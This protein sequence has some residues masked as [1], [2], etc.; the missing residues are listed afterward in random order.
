MRR[1]GLTVALSA[2]AIALAAGGAQAAT[3]PGKYVVPGNVPGNVPGRAAA[4]VCGPPYVGDDPRLG[5]VRLPRNGILG[6]IVRGYDPLGDVRPHQFVKR[7]WL[8]A[9]KS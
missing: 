1:V 4:D 7:Y 3:L 9:Q 2:V 8:P 5:P 6:H